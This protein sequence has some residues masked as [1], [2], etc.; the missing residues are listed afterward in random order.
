[1]VRSANGK[2]F[3]ALGG[4]TFAPGFIGMSWT[5]MGCAG[6]AA[7]AL[8]TSTRWMTKPRGAVEAVGGVDGL[9]VAGL[10]AMAILATA[11]LFIAVGLVPV[12]LFAKAILAN[13]ELFID[14]GGLVGPGPV[15]CSVVV[16]GVPV[17]PAPGPGSGP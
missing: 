10:F 4:G 15:A 1:M 16:P 12:V 14:M 7:L 5:F 3:A 9:R 13:A 11:E 6:G 2:G 17:P 8:G